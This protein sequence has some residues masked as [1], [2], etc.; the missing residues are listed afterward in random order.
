MT[1]ITIAFICLGKHVTVDCY[2]KFGK[3]YWDDTHDNKSK[4]G[5]YFIY[6]YQKKYVY[7]HKIIN[8]LPYTQRPPDMVWN[9]TR[10]IL[11]LGPRLIEFDWNDWIN[12]FGKGAPYTNNYRSTQTSSWSKEKLKKFSFNFENLD[13]HINSKMSGLQI[14]TVENTFSKMSGLQLIDAVRKFKKPCFT[15][16]IIDAHE[17][18]GFD[19]N[20][21]TADDIY[22]R[23]VA[24]RDSA[25]EQLIYDFMLQ[26]I[27]EQKRSLD[28]IINYN[29]VIDLCIKHFGFKE[30][31]IRLPD[32]DSF[33]R[34]IETC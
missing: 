18:V 12:H 16:H 3:K 14:N 17:S 15:Q 2:N 29:N 6:Y 7:I 5:Y 8:I 25:C 22:D 4:I 20:D 28:L 23:I 27:N 24:F 33:K 13:L 34:L 26:N 10:Q 32:H 21:I 31:N 1:G 19:L 11:C 9:S 30:K